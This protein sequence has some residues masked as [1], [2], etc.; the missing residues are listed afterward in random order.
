MKLLYIGLVYAIPDKSIVRQVRVGMRGDGVRLVARRLLEKSVVSGG[1]VGIRVPWPCPHKA[2][3]ISVMD[4]AGYRTLPV[5]RAQPG[6]LKRCDRGVPA[7]AHR[8]GP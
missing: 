1:I 2:R 4:L 6:P 8:A 7:I 5:L 3:P